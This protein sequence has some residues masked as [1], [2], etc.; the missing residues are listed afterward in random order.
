MCPFYWGYSAEG[1]RLPSFSES[2]AAV[3]GREDLLEIDL[4]LVGRQH[5]VVVEA[6]HQAMPG[7]CSRYQSGRC[8]E[9]H[10]G[11]RSPCRYWEGEPPPFASALNFG[12][13]P[14]MESDRPPCADH[15]QLARCLLLA[16]ELSGRLGLQPHLWLVVPAARWP[17]V[18]PDWMDFVER[19]SDDA[20]WRRL[21]VVAWE[22]IQALGRAD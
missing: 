16:R 14:T 9:V 7:L 10:G 21:R 4:L 6:K 20:E 2:L 15:Y 3:A 1:E 13:R 8:P 22:S 11:G 17:D 5:L 18:R 19:V 12:A